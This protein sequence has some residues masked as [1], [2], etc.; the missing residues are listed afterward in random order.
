M[1][2]AMK[3]AAIRETFQDAWVAV[4]ITTVDNADVPVAGMVLTHSREKGDVDRLAQAYLLQH[5][6][7]RIFLCLT[8][9]PIPEGVEVALALGSPG[10]RMLGPRRCAAGACQGAGS[11][12]RMLGRYRL[13]RHGGEP[14]PGI[15]VRDH[16]R[17]PSHTA[18]TRGGPPRG[19]HQTPRHPGSTASG[20]PRRVVAAGQWG[21]GC[22][23][24]PWRWHIPC[25]R[26]PSGVSMTR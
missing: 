7:A 24:R 18:P 1:A 3:M 6:A 11:G 5:P 25:D 17:S 2:T 8:G 12:F 19:A 22:V 20:C 16:S 10:A 4:A 26:F 21:Q 9:D 15:P 13:S 14:G 23:S